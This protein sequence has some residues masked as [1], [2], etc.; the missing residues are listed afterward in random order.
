MTILKNVEIWFA[1]LDP[2]FPNSKLD[3]NNPTW[4]V[5]CR[6]TDP[7]QKKEW[8]EAGIKSRLVVGKE[9]TENEGLAVLTADGKKQWKMNLKKRS[10]NAKKEPSDP[11]KVVDGHMNDVNPNTIGNGSI[12]NLRVYQY[13]YKKADGTD[14]LAPVLMAVQLV[15]LIKLKARAPGESFEMMETVVEDAPEREQATKENTSEPSK[16]AGTPTPTPKPVNQKPEDK[17]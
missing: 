13:P 17:F 12:A 2:R 11:V 14:G 10:L 4:E 6:T 9:G 1:K 5:Q 15:K 16:P 3:K 8:D 7:E